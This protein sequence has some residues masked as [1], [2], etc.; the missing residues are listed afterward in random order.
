MKEPLLIYEDWLA[1]YGEELDIADAESGR[2]REHG[3]HEFKGEIRERQY[4]EY[5][6]AH[7]EKDTGA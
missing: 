4:E 1:K 7:F 5:I 3:Y 2:D 6:D